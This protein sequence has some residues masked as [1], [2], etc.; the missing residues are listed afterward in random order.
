MTAI[1]GPGIAA[2]H[3]RGRPRLNL[4]VFCTLIGVI[5][6]G[7][8]GLPLAV[9]CGRAGFRTIGFDI[10]RSG[11]FAVGSYAAVRPSGEWLVGH[12]AMPY[13]LR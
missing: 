5:G 10:E 12:T 9:A 4:A 8:V 1:D 3:P 11:M 2:L 13:T 6:L 7:Y